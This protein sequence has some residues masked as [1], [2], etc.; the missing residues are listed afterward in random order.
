MGIFLLAVV[1]LQ[2]VGLR[3]ESLAIV[4]IVTIEFEIFFVL[5]VKIFV[6]YFDS[7]SCC[8]YNET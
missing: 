1:V 4:G 3:I 2:L 6:V 7:N 5:F 8:L